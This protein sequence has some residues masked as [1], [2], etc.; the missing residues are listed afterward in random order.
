MVNLLFLQSCAFL[1][2]I[3]LPLCNAEVTKSLP[4]GGATFTVTSH[5][6]CKLLLRTL[7]VKFLMSLRSL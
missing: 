3:D 6:V 7:Q 4:A 1:R 2:L 5:I